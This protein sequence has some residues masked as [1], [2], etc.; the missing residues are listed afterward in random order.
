VAGRPHHVLF[1][2][3]GN[4]ARSILAEALLQRLGQGRFRAYSAGSQPRGAVHPLALEVLKAAHHPTEELR[5]KSWDEFAGP[6]APPLDFIFTVCGNAAAEACPHWPGHPTTAH[7]G[8]DDPA[9]V[10]GP[11]E[12][13]R[14]A[15]ERTYREMEDRI[16]RFVS[17]PLDS[18][19]GA[20]LRQQL[21]EI[22]TS[23]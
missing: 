4:S 21:Q 3:T 20:P 12:A 17:L 2:C 18:L 1:V 19:D 10:E 16:R 9:A 8:V 22:G 11:E 23:S 7:W 13:R 5:S 14:H 6:G 15:F